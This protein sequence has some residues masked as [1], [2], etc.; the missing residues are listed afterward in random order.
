MKNLNLYT[1]KIHNEQEYIE[2]TRTLKVIYREIIRLILKKE[3]YEKK[4]HS[5]EMK[6]NMLEND[7]ASISKDW[8]N[9]KNN[10]RLKI[11]MFKKLSYINNLKEELSRYKYS[12]YF[13]KVYYKPSHG[14]TE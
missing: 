13:L 4:I 2:L 8:L 9:N 7:L 6:I 10:E 3:E 14:H 1:D 5:L 12:L 11:S